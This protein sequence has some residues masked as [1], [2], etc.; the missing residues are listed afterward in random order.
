MFDLT[1][2]TALVTG[3]SLGLCATGRCTADDAA[4][5]FRRVI[6]RNGDSARE[7]AEKA[8]PLEFVVLQCLV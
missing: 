3:A 6:L 5:I 2:Q 1:G 7:R 8:V 4:Q